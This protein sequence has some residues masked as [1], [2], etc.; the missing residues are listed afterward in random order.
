MI[1]YNRLWE[2]M[3]LQPVDELSDE[4]GVQPNIP[5]PKGKARVS[6]PKSSPKKNSP[7]EFY[8]TQEFTI[9]TEA[10]ETTR[11]SR[12]PQRG[13]QGKGNACDET[14]GS[15]CFAFQAEEGQSGEG[16]LPKGQ[17]VWL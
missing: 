3:A 17:Q 1:G 4:G 13:S 10:S 11:Q 2:A 14:S 5:K 7:R 16:V 15:S 6:K 9:K 8:S 12:S